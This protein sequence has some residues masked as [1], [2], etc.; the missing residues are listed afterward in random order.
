MPERFIATALTAVFIGV[1]VISGVAYRYTRGAAEEMAGAQMVQALELLDRDVSGR[2]RDI[3]R[4]TVL[5][6]QEEVLPLALEDS[7]LGRSARVSAQRRLDAFVQVGGF[8]HLL[9]ADRTGTVVLSTL[10]LGETRLNI[11]DR[12][13]FRSAMRGV[14]TLELVERSRL[15]GGP[16]LV[17][18]EPVRG[19][20]GGV[21]GMVAAVTAMDVFARDILDSVHLGAAGGAYILSGTGQLL[22]RPAWAG[23]DDFSPDARLLEMLRK[24]DGAGQGVSLTP[25]AVQRAGRQRLITFRRNAPTDWLLVV[26]ADEG[27]ILAPARRLAAASGGISLVTL[28]CVALAL[29]ALQRAMARLRRSEDRFSSLFLLSPDSVLLVAPESG[30][31]EDVNDAAATAFGLTRQA[32]AG[33]TVGDLGILPDDAVRQAV[34]AR[35]KDEGTI[36]NVEVVGRASGEP[37]GPDGPDGPSG[38]GGREVFHSLSGQAMDIGGRPLFMLVLRDVTE[39]KKMQEVMIQTEKMI[40]VGGIAAGIAHEINNPLGAIM[41]ASQN[42]QQRMNTVLPANVAAA[43]EAGLDLDALQQYLRI[44]K[45][46][47]FIE[48]IRAAA[49]RASSIIRHMLDFS[50][51]SAARSTACDLRGLVARAVNLAASDYDLKKNYDFRKI[52]IDIRMADGLPPVPCV[53]TEVEQVLLNLLRNAAQALAGMD[54]PRDDPRIVLRAFPL[55][56]WLRLEMEDNGPGMPPEVQRRIFEP[57]YTTKPPGVGTGLGLSVSYFI[58]TKGH[59]GRMTVESHPG[60][61]SVFRVDLPVG[62]APVCPVH[63]PPVDGGG[64]PPD[65]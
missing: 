52:S 36:R 31:V 15:T 32:V 29:G 12:D 9:L 49:I 20:D 65:G 7:Y 39:L 58:I 37:D 63:S 46:D 30:V 4:R 45:V 44:R 6:S 10:P 35:L 2:V 40:S 48:D 56:G 34:W 17:T 64:A 55:E 61:G 14:S 33:R 41:Q 16:V 60:E 43:Q 38:A 28:A 22:A 1:L 11:S 51:S 54:P 8:S 59:E 50:R 3:A 25:Q 21:A 42:M 47:R 5:V 53:E 62:G 13:T 27:D 18:A 26:E 19:S 23:P 24:V 57:F